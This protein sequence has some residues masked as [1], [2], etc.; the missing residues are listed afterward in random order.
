M[1]E[2]DC[3]HIAFYF[4]YK[5]LSYFYFLKLKFK[6]KFLVLVQDLSF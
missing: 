4:N 3:K 1:F 5:L 6:I 2:M